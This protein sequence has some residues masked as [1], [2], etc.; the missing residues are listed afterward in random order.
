[1]Y[2]Q[3]RFQASSRV[4]TVF[5]P[6]RVGRIQEMSGSFGLGI[7]EVDGTWCMLVWLNVNLNPHLCRRRKGCS[8]QVPFDAG[9]PIK[10]QD[11]TPGREVF[12]ERRRELRSSEAGRLQ[13]HRSGGGGKAQDVV[14]W[15]GQIRKMQ[16]CGCKLVRTDRRKHGVNTGDFGYSR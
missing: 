9:H 10:H 1:M 8:T 15:G 11:G 2:S 5:S 4:G 14:V 3:S 13:F 6:S 12:A 7:A 16:R